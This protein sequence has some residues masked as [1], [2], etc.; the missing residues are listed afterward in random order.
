MAS[1]L[2]SLL[3]SEGANVP[4]LATPILSYNGASQFRLI[5]F[6]VYPQLY[7][8]LSMSRLVSFAVLIAIIVI[9]GLLF[10]KVLF[11]FFIRLFRLPCW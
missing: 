9:I 3:G 7:V 11:G 1:L 6:V 4:L 2:P 10:Y 8:Q 5:Q